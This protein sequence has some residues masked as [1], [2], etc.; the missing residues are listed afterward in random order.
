[1]LKQLR[2]E[3][4]TKAKSAAGLEIVIQPDG[5]YLLHLI[6]LKKQ[7]SS[8]LSTIQRS[9]LSSFADAKAA[10]DAKTPLMIIVNGKGIIHRK[11]HA[12]EQDQAATLL[13]KLFPNANAEEFIIQKTPLSTEEAFVSVI[14][15]TAFQALIQELITNG[16]T[17]IVACF[18]GP[19][20]ISGI[21]PIAEHSLAHSEL[22]EV[23][24]FRLQIHN[25]QITGIEPTTFTPQ[26]IV[27]IGSEQFSYELL[28]PFAAA[29]AY[30]T[31]ERNDI[32]NSQ[33]LNQLKEEFDQ[34]Q[35][36][37]L[38]GWI[39]LIATFLILIANYFVFNHYWNLNKE[40]NT[41]L[42]SA[43]AALT[44]YEKL[45]VEF[46]QK[47]QVLKE[48][49]LLENSRTSFYADQLARELPASIQLIGLNI[50]PLKKKKTGEEDKGFAFENQNILVSG[51]CQ[52]NTELN[53]WMKKIKKL[54]WVQD[55]T[56]IN[57]KQDNLK[58]N[59][60]F[61]IEIQIK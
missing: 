16:L 28:I 44:R 61:L 13:N 55:V 48:N 8:L 51:N 27:K 15:L 20:V 35:K 31:N 39:L 29:L 1:M 25:Q 32:F 24:N 52:R 9:A 6:V 34:K 3:H 46:D 59:G 56:L 47:Q 7:Q 40:M 23:P 12:T 33:A 10:V 36:F 4:I 57:Y 2:L 58:E 38:R 49:G 14:R 45:K 5:G 42:E 43:Q 41:Q 37:E 17:N 30:Y 50:H 11:V 54:S 26:G 18:L 19:F 21:L 53:D 22:I 60:I